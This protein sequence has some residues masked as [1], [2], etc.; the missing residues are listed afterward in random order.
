MA[1]LA[2]AHARA[3]THTRTRTENESASRH[4]SPENVTILPQIAGKLKEKDV[5]L[6]LLKEKKKGGGG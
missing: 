3:H 5:F 4:N 6:D 1:L 2:R